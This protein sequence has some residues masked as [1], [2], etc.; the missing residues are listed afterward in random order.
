MGVHEFSS[1]K[2]LFQTAGIGNQTADP[3][4]TN[5]LLPPTQQGNPSL[6]FM[7]TNCI[8]WTSF[9]KLVYQQHLKMSLIHILTKSSEVSS[10]TC[11]HL[12]LYCTA[13]TVNFLIW[14]VEQGYIH[15]I[16]STSFPNKQSINVSSVTGRIGLQYSI[17]IIRIHFCFNHSM[18]RCSYRICL[19]Q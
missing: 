14:K 11:T 17:A 5:P 12:D 7:V 15:Q 18:S 9:Y 6:L 8:F 19:I 10:C 4:V 2:Q 16:L 13:C 3:W 1:R